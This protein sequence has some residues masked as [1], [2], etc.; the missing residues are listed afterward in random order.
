M[1]REELIN[2]NINQRWRK[3]RISFFEEQIKTVGRLT[4]ILSDMPKRK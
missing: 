2:F 1:T 3:A 4:S